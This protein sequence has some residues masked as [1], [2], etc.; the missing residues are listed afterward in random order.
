MPEPQV[1][2]VSVVYCRFNSLLTTTRLQTHPARQVCSPG[3]AVCTVLAGYTK[4][5]PRNS[6]PESTRKHKH[7]HK[8]KH[9]H[10]L[11][12]TYDPVALRNPSVC[13][14]GY[15]HILAVSILS[16]D[17]KKGRTLPPS[18]RIFFLL[19]FFHSPVTNPVQF[20]QCIHYKT[21]HCSPLLLLRRLHLHYAFS[22]LRL[23]HPRRCST[24]P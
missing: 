8:H 5:S 17:I 2:Q 10:S 7:K 20:L 13:V 12:S 1:R 22:G 4:P 23:R 21:S 15:S 18:D 6:N 11:T 3:V 9:N 14:C 24:D 16:A 19:F